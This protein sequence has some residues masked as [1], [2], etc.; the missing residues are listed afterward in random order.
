M[1]SKERVLCALDHKEADRVP[2]GEWGIDHDTVEKVIG[3]ETYWR[4]R[5]KSTLA[6]W[7]GKR[8]EVVESEKKDIVELIEKLDQDLVPVFLVPPKDL[9]PEQI[10]QINDTTWKDREGRTYKY[11]AG[12][13]AIL[14]TD[15][16]Q[17]RRFESAEELREY[18]E[19]VYIPDAG[20]KIEGKTSDGYELELENESQLELVRFVVDKLGDKRFIFARGF[21]EFSL[22]VEGSAEELFLFIGL[23]PDLARVGFELITE[24]NIAKAEIFID[25]GVDAIMP[26][27]DFSDST[28]PM[29]SPQSIRDIFLPGM[30]RLS[31]YCHKAGV[32]V[33]SHN[34]GNNWKIM[35]MLIEAGYE[36]WQS[37]ACKTADMDLKSLKE[38]YGDQIAFWGGINIETLVSGTPEEN[39][40]DVL[41]ALKYAA[42]GG[43]L[44]LGTS[45]SVCYG[46]RYENYL[47]ALETAHKYGTYPIRI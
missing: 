39:R 41:Y 33:M 19:S 3:H 4:A 47:T 31:D 13:D 38:K 37:I 8:D 17:A 45:N 24:L 23:Q 28:G 20:F 15:H 34:C 30:K 6:L 35:D 12:N 10:T 16:G 25:E 11:S 40:E 29:I 14:C 44:I 42:P 21:S 32:R 18:F 5:K 26:G 46:S 9:E 7:D 22:P 36:C 1:N 2:I 27:G 43:G